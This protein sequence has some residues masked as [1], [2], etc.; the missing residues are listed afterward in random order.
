MLELLRTRRSIRQFADRPV[1][2]EMLDQLVE[3]I[4]RSPSSRG[5]NPWRLI[6]VDDKEMLAHLSQCRPSGAGFLAGVA[7]GIVVLGDEPVTDVWVED[8]SIASAVAH[9]TAHSLGLGS[10][11]VQVRNRKHADGSSAEDYIK[12]ALDVPPHFRVESVIGIGWPNV[13]PPAHAASTLQREK[14]FT[15]TFGTPFFGEGV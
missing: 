15:G 2:A 8:C 13:L 7:L 4:L 14:V 12:R 1:L 9:F 10:S 3:A 11:W 5:R 6:V